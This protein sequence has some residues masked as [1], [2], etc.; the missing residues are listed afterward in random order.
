MKVKPKRSLAS[1]LTMGDGLPTSFHEPPS[2]EPAASTTS[3]APE[4]K[5]GANRGI[6][7]IEGEEEVVG[8]P[9]ERFQPRDR[10]RTKQG[11]T[12]HPYPQE[13]PYMQAYDPV[14]LDK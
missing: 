12:L 7:E 5:D 2:S 14:L 9:V 3:S 4:S 1:L 11:M 10:F 13:A 8:E 6:E